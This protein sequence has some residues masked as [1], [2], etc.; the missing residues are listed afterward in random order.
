V[1][2]QGRDAALRHVAILIFERANTK[3]LLIK[4]TGATGAEDTRTALR[5]HRAVVRGLTKMPAQ[6][7]TT[8]CILSPPTKEER[9]TI[10]WEEFCRGA[11]TEFSV[12]IENAG[13]LD[14]TRDDS[15]WGFLEEA[16]IEWNQH[17]MSE[18][19]DF[20][21]ASSEQALAQARIAGLRQARAWWHP[22][23]GRVSLQKTGGQQAPQQ[24]HA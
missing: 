16:L 10:L 19:R 8:V 14:Q 9:L 1:A 12:S 22:D 20:V 7:V 5:E 15:M 18:A 4:A 2:L 13:T 3:D 23:E 11:A 21:R 6:D 17:G 24:A